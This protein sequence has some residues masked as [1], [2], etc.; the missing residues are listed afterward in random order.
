MASE[1]RVLD[2][3][4]TR[5]VY[6]VDTR[7]I[8][9]LR[10]WLEGFWDKVLTAF[11]AMAEREAT[12]SGNNEPTMSGGIAANLVREVVSVRAPQMVAWRV[13]AEKMS[14]WWPLEAFAR[15]AAA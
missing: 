10:N 8:G 14:A 2:A 5:R 6:A 4:G 15:T 1:D 13:F 9:S 12:R 3:E 11:K 7:G